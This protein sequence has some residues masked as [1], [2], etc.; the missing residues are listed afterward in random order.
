[1]RT[2]SS[3]ELRCFAVFESY[4]ESDLN[5]YVIPHLQLRQAPSGEVICQERAPGDCCFFLVE[6]QVEVMVSTSTGKQEV[7]G[8]LD[9]GQV[10]GQIALLDGGRRTATCVALS[11][12][13]LLVL[14]RE[15][16]DSLLSAGQRFA[17]DLLRQIG[18]SLAVQ[19]RQATENLSAMSESRVEDTS[20]ISERL[21][22]FIRPSQ[23]PDPSTPS[24]TPAPKMALRLR[25]FSL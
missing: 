14:E 12:C 1:M 24:Q 15:Q 21:R 3:Q 6:G 5:Q 13:V 7:I 23:S 25:T 16:F 2:V 20:A 4:T 9:A 10:F 17:A 18:T 19:V 22:S 8:H 11:P